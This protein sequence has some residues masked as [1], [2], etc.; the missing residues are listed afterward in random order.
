MNFPVCAVC[1]HVFYRKISFYFPLQKFHS[2]E[3]EFSPYFRSLCSWWIHCYCKWNETDKGNDQCEEI[4]TWDIIRPDVE[5]LRLYVVRIYQSSILLNGANYKAMFHKYKISYDAYR[6]THFIRFCANDIVIYGV[7]RRWIGVTK[8]AYS[9]WS[10]FWEVVSCKFINEKAFSFGIIICRLPLPLP[11][12]Y[13]ALFSASSHMYT[14]RNYIIRV[15]DGCKLKTRFKSSRWN[16]ILLHHL[17]WGSFCEFI[18]FFVWDVDFSK[19]GELKM[20]ISI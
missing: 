18:N 15:Y 10:A 17:L 9:I 7:L 12:Q 5:K 11:I 16:S 6:T 4:I 8:F 3:V 20:H 2:I 1:F 19:K 14:I 13:T